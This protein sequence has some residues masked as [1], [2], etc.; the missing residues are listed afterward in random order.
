MLKNIYLVRHC[1][2]EGQEP[3]ANLTKKGEVD[4]TLLI[5]KLKDK[6]IDS[7]ISSPY[8]RAHHTIRP[9]ADEFN[10]EVRFDD[11]LIERKLTPTYFANWVDLLKQSFNDLNVSF[12]GG[13]S[14][15]D[16]MRRIV[17]VTEEALESNNHNIV[18]V[19]HGNLIA[20]LLKY[21]DERIGFDEWLSLSNP[22]IFELRFI[23]KN[24]PV[25]TRIE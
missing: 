25:I 18:L 17:N 20:L 8:I 19:S 9:F 6:H 16:A 13:E 5:H 10:I 12:E 11:R 1:K 23:E 21:F 24:Q 3:E 14:S 4:A 7:I 15:Y 22:D 2:A